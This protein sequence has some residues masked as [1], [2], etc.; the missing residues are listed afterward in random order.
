[1][2]FTINDQI[3]M[4]LEQVAFDVGPDFKRQS[5]LHSGQKRKCVAEFV[6]LVRGWGEKQD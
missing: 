4:I 5:M 6:Y 1:L 2:N 3:N